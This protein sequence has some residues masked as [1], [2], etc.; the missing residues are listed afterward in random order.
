MAM[1]VALGATKDLDH[2]MLELEAESAPVVLDGR[3]LFRVRGSPLQPADKRAAAIGRRL[4][5]FAADLTIPAD[6]LR[7]QSEAEVM[8]IMAGDLAIVGVSDSDAGDRPRE[9]AASVLLRELTEAVRTYRAAR[10]PRALLVNGGYALLWSAVA[11]VLLYG[12]MRARSILLERLRMR[13]VAGGTEVKIQSMR[14]I[15]WSQIWLAARGL[16]NIFTTLAGLII[17]YLYLSTVLGL[18]PW[19]HSLA[20]DLFE[21]FLA[22]VQVLGTSFL[23]SVPDLTFI[24]VVVLIAHYVLRALQLMFKGLETGAIKFEGFDPD[25]SQPS[26]RIVRLLVVAFALVIAYPYIPGSE[27]QAF[28]GVSLFLGVVFSLGSSSVISNVIAG[29]TMTYRRAFRIGDRILVGDRTGIVTEASVLVTRLRTAKNEEVVVPNS[30][31][32]NSSVVNYSALARRDGLVL[33]TTVGI[34]YETPWRQVEAMLIMAAKRTSGLEHDPAPYVLKKSLGD[35]CVIYE[36]NAITRIATKINVLYS[37]LHENILDV[38]NEYGVQ[39]MT[40]AYEGDPQK[41]KLVPREEWH[42]EPAKPRID[43]A[44]ALMRDE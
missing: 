7:L 22:P 32:L 23:S 26:Y 15:Q 24:A 21:L 12:L 44:G 28:K 19:T 29:Y 9:I 13:I 11:A 14:F 37:A 25:W 16:V 33:H 27:S 17:A 43:G 42:L 1:P 40:P 39:I 36:I 38:F 41:P 18:F 5:Q 10:E 34:G 35:F 20:D 6:A 31:I 30:E 2:R 8:V 4:E 3:E